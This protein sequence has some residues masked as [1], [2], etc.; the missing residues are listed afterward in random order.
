MYQF[1]CRTPTIK[2][3]FQRFWNKKFLKKLKSKVFLVGHTIVM[4]VEAIFRGIKGLLQH[5]SVWLL[6]FLISNGFSYTIATNFLY[7]SYCN[8][9]VT[10]IFTTTTTLI[11]ILR[12]NSPHSFERDNHLIHQINV[13]LSIGQ[14]RYIEIQPQ[15]IDLSTRLWGINTEFVGF[16]P[17][18]LVLKSIIGLFG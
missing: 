9:T 5:S 18:S 10:T 7:F 14:F 1:C 12:V 15:T 3:G 11:S 13:K 16:I 8:M 2:N 4:V 17:Q 6:H